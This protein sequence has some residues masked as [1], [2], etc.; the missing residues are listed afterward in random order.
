ML[1][2]VRGTSQYWIHRYYEVR[3]MMRAFGPPTWFVTASA[4][5]YAWQDLDKHLRAVNADIEKGKTLGELCVLDP[6]TVSRHFKLREE[7][8]VKFLKDAKPLGRVDRL[9]VR[10]E[11][12]ARCAG[13]YHCLLW[14]NDALSSVRHQTLTSRNSLK[15]TSR[16]RFPIL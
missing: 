14:N 8:L 15:I 7:A 13:H 3:T 4:G 12:Q 10:L 1:G 6:V 16:A 9:F 5:D 11:Y 2:N